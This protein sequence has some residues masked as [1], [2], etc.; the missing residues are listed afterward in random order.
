MLIVEDSRDVA[1]YLAAILKSEYRIECAQD[2]KSGFE[3]A[4][5]LIP[6]IILSDVMMPEMGGLGLLEKVKNDIRTSHIPVVLLTAKADVAS[7]LSGLERGAD[8]YLSK[9]F[10]EKELH[11][12]LKNLIEIRKK[13]HE[14]YASPE[15]FPPI[16]E[17]GYKI[18]DA[19]MSKVKQVLEANLDD[20]EFGISQI[21]RELA[22]SRTQLYRKFK[23]VSNKTIAEYFKSLRLNKAKTLLS[24]TSMNVTEVAFAAGFKN[25]SYFSREFTHHFGKSPK[26]FRN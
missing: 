2:G 20:D 11:I 7:R 21:C 23:S 6:D 4:L 12:V 14:R 10:D 16:P 17:N 13:L 24:A 5:N 19:F 26:E 22:V 1:D 9:P 8:V 18:E 3:K 15:N 25:L